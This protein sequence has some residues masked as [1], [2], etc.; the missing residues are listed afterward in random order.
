MGEVNR[1]R[2]KELAK[3]EYNNVC[4]D[5]EYPNPDWASVTIG[6]FLCYEC[7]LIHRGLGSHIS[8]A[9]SF[10]LDNWDQASLLTM[11]RN[12]NELAKQHYEKVL[13]E[14]WIRAKYERKEFMNKSD[15]VYN[16]GYME[17]FLMKKGKKDKKLE[18]R[19]FV[20]SQVDQTLKYYV[21]NNSK[22]PKAVINI[23]DLNAI[24]C[25]PCKMKTVKNPNALHLT[26]LK[27]G[28]TRSIYVY[29]EDGKEIVEWYNAIR[30]A[31]FH[32]LQIAYPTCSPDE[33]LPHLT[34]DFVKEGWLWKTGPKVGDSYKK[35][36][37]ILDYRKLMYLEDP[38]DPYPK[39]EI[40]LGEKSKQ[41][42]ISSG[43]P[44]PLKQLHFGFILKTPD[45][46]WLFSAE[47][48]EERKSWIHS[49]SSVLETPE[50]P[51]DSSVY[52]R[53]NLRNSFSYKHNKSRDSS[54]SN[55]RNSG[56]SLTGGT[57]RKGKNFFSFS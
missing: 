1:K 29:S 17:G 37:F 56:S 2:L 53:Q 12:G 35:R 7:A 13:R 20:L 34:R 25:D 48:E 55:N 49:I 51:Q 43:I 28:Y 32:Y 5:C 11:E 54:S 50:S 31:K 38:L 21:K 27:D 23:S 3:R 52:L 26:Y 33:L 40:Y 36:W 19:K 30:A 14:Q 6:V 8:I 44:P 46:T 22:T 39:G 16:R 10:E 41:F 47:T 4:A 45:R 18:K 42:N 15:A 57:I 24:F 9:K